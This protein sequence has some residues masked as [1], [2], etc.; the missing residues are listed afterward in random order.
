MSKYYPNE[1]EIIHE[2]PFPEKFATSNSSCTR[3]SLPSKTEA[4]FGDENKLFQFL[5]G[6]V[7]APLTPI[8]VDKSNKPAEWEALEQRVESLERE[9][10]AAITAA[11]S[12]N[13][14]NLYSQED[15]ARGTQARG[16]KLEDI[17]H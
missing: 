14:P 6:V 17:C 12:E 16:A 15:K 11:P 1:L 9:L 3:S 13:V 7:D 10:D 4:D 8:V 2:Y 5:L